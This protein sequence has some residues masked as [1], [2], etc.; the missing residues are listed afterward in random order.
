MRYSIRYLFKCSTVLSL[1][2]L[3]A[4]SLSA[5]TGPV[6][7]NPTGRRAVDDKTAEAPS[8]EKG[9]RIKDLARI[10]G[11]RSNQLLGYGIVIGLQGTGDQR[12]KLAL[13]SMQ[14]LLANLGQDASSNLELKNV[15]A[16]LV[17]A[18]IPPFAKKGDRITV[19][20]SSIGDA[21][22]LDGGVLV[23]TPLQAGN[24][25]LYAVAQGPLLSAAREGRS[26]DSPKNVAVVPGG[27]LIE[28]D[29]RETTLADRRLRVQLRDFDFT[30]LS[31]VHQAILPLT[32]EETLKG[33]EAKIEGG[34]VLVTLPENVEPIGLL[35]RI[36]NL[37]VQPSYKA[38]VVINQRTGTI[39]FGGDVRIDPVAVSRPPSGNGRFRLQ[40]QE[41]YQGIYVRS[42][43][44]QQKDETVQ[45]IEASSVAELV[46]ALNKLGAGV[47]DIISILEA[48]RDSGALHAEVV[49][50]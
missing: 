10:D 11:V 32:Q 21:K 47:R 3:S 2:L 29:L 30:T 5:Q 6:Q 14:N 44:G 46:G 13:R 8:E 41:A 12:S 28:K 31:R 50:L 9:I 7:P 48:L 15:A 40:R 37:R 35:S 24:G 16:V 18:E 45:Q 22:S 23:Q 39:V 17:T 38:R 42:P 36:E 27:A 25:E 34:S 33:M 20:V 49:I 1:L 43:G 4:L 26:N 19:V